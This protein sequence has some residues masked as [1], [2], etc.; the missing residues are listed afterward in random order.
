MN[1]P[2]Q[3][4]QYIEALIFASQQALSIKDITDA[5]K[6]TFE[7]KISTED[8]EQQIEQITAKYEQ[9]DFAMQLMPIAGG[10]MFMSKPQY[11][12]IIGDYLRQNE[13]KK[14]SK[15][16]LETLAI[17][18]YKQPITKSEMESIRG[19]GCDY[20]V[21]KLLEKELVEITGRH[22]GPGRPLLYG[23]TVKF[24]NH[25]GIKDTT[26]LPKLK[27]FELVD[28]AIGSEPAISE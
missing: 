25:F 7:F 20:T 24:L 4:E 28:N 19:V 18:A 3:L 5:I 6:V 16:A 1:H 27:E 15:A 14:L 10:Y 17:I 22:E 21:Q 23:T 2:D 26:E 8:L 9:D 13:R 12:K 11:H